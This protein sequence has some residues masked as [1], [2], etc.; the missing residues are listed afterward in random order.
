MFQGAEN[1]NSLMMS[2]DSSLKSEKDGN[3]DM[4]YMQQ[5]E[6]IGIRLYT[7]YVWLSV[8]PSVCLWTAA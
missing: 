7:W 1:P 2:M 4:A 8:C 6:F 3:G 5:Q